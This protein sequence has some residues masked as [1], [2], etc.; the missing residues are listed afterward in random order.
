MVNIINNAIDKNEF[1]DKWK[2]ARVSPIPKIDQP[3]DM[4]DYRPISILPVLSKVYERVILYQLCDFIERNAIY[5]ANQSGFRK[6]HSTTTLLL[7]LR[8]D[9]IRAMNR[10]EVT[11]AILIDYSKAFDTINH[12]TLIKKLRSL[13]F[14]ISSLKLIMSY[15]SNRQQFVQVNDKR[16]S[17]LPIHFGVPQGSIQGPVLFNLYVTELSDQITSHSIQYA[18]DTSLYRH[19]ILID[20]LSNILYRMNRSYN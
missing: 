12:N 1:P 13:N 4:K 2:I 6:G 11:L 14:S 19:S 17:T 8:D 7:K 18:D 15:L 20:F 3:L 10:S 9:I 5:S 16:S